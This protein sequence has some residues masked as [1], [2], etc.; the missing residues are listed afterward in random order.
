MSGLCYVHPRA[1]V[2]TKAATEARRW[3]DEHEKMQ[4]VSPLFP[5]QV[6]G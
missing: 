2:E 3:K 4:K 6:L 5:F 1:A